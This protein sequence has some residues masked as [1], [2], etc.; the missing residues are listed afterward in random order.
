M[1]PD[2]QTL[3]RERQRQ[4]DFNVFRV[5]GQTRMEL[6]H[7]NFLA[8][9][10]D[11]SGSHKQ[12]GAILQSFLSFFKDGFGLEATEIP[13]MQWC[14]AAKVQPEWSDSDGRIDVLVEIPGARTAVVIEY[15]LDAAE[16]KGQ[17]HRYDQLEVCNR[18]GWRVLKLFVTP[19]G[20]SAEGGSDWKNVG[21]EQLAKWLRADMDKWKG[22]PAS[23]LTTIG[24]FAEVVEQIAFE[25]LHPADA[26]GRIN[27]RYEPEG[28]AAIAGSHQALSKLSGLA[29][30]RIILEVLAEVC[31]SRKLNRWREVGSR[32]QE[33]IRGWLGDPAALVEPT[34]GR[35][36]SWCR[37]VPSSWLSV[38]PPIGDEDCV[39]PETICRDH[40]AWL[41]IEVWEDASRDR[42]GV[43]KTALIVAKTTDSDMSKKLEQHLRKLGLTTGSKGPGWQKFEL[44]RVFDAEKSGRDVEA[45]VSAIEANVR[46]LVAKLATLPSELREL[47]SRS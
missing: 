8:W 23:A 45:C 38:L 34:D 11:P 2:F 25:Y 12:R 42:D 46:S 15:K 3:V 30:T 41:L 21:F 26:C 18:E 40:R 36:T 37:A 47:F 14:D 19:D 16:G 31:R 9:L 33:S 24:H 5:V 1:D 7:S 20:R 39:H 17:L 35:E 43:W 44:Q 28:M 6:C 27:Q 4:N 13:D 32:V 22:L 10:L 29:D